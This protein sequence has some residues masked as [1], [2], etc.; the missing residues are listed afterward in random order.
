MWGEQLKACRGEE[1]SV[2]QRSGAV[3]GQVLL[4]QVTRQADD[5]GV[6]TLCHMGKHPDV[7][8]AYH[9]KLMADGR[10]A[11]LCQSLKVYSTGTV[12]QICLQQKGA[13]N[14]IILIKKIVCHFYFLG[15]RFLIIP[16][17]RGHQYPK[18]I[19]FHISSP[20]RPQ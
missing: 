19:M 20:D 10:R 8:G 12:Q 17:W 5:P 9:I 7:G 18:Y 11:P 1:P 3:L 15:R 13:K 16:V 6:L 2:A 14:M 4:P